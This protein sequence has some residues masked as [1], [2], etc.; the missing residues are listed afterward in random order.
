M[1][2]SLFIY[3]FLSI[4]WILAQE[5]RIGLSSRIGFPLL[6]SGDSTTDQSKATLT[7][8]SSQLTS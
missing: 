7:Y 1:N 2:F 8:L 3:Y 6:V 4:S 5:S